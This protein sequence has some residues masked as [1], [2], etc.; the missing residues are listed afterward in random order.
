MVKCVELEDHEF[1]AGNYEVYIFEVYSLETQEKQNVSGASCIWTLSDY[2]QRGTPPVI[3]KSGTI[4]SEAGDP[5][6]YRF[7]VVLE[8]EDTFGLYGKFYQQ[9]Q[10]LDDTSGAST[11]A[12]GF[13]Y[14]KRNI[15]PNVI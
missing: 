9:A 3:R 10:I 8:T 15:D 4:F 1:I 13:I 7:R 5:Y 11:F 6:P 2:T 14:I 12:Q